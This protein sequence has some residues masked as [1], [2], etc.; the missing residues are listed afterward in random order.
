[1]DQDGHLQVL[2]EQEP[3]VHDDMR[4]V[5][6]TMNPTDRTDI[7]KRIIGLAKTAVEELKK[8]GEEAFEHVIPR[9][10][11]QDGIPKTTT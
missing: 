1:V 2:F 3:Q 7:R 9:S 8:S 11:F 6:T 4:P 10:T 5:W